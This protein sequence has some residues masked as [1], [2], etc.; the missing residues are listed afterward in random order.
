MA[1][2][3]PLLEGAR[4]RR[5]DHDYDGAMHLLDLR[6]QAM[7]RSGV[8]RSDERWASSW[9]QRATCEQGGKK[10]VKKLMGCVRANGAKD[11][12][13]GKK[14]KC[15]RCHVDLKK[16]ELKTKDDAGAVF[17]PRKEM[18]KWIAGCECNWVDPPK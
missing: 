9:L 18:E 8:P 6:D 15:T 17:D 11:M 12:P 2:L 5:A 10:A 14:P 4:E 16:Y 13:D 7:E 1:A 3:E